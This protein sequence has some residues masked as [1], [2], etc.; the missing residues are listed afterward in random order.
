M[1]SIALT[2]D[3]ALTGT[4]AIDAAGSGGSVLVDGAISGNESLSLTSALSTVEVTGT[5]DLSGAIG[6]ALVGSAYDSITFD[7]A[8]N[9]SG[10]TNGGTVSLSSSQSSVI[11]NDITT[12]GT[13]GLG[14]NISLQ[15]STLM[16]STS[17][18]ALPLGTIQFTGTVFDASGGTLGGAIE[19]SSSGHASFPSVATIFSS[20]SLNNSMTFT[21]SSFTMGANEAMTIYGNVTI[22]VTG[23]VTVSDIIALNN[24]TIDASSIYLTP[25]SSEQI[26]AYFGTLYTSE[27][28]HLL[29]GTTPVFSVSV[30]PPD[31]HTGLTGATEAQ[32]IYAP[33]SLALNYDTSIPPPPPP[34]PVPSNSSYL[35]AVADAQLSDMLPVIGTCWEWPYLPTF[36][37]DCQEDRL[38]RERYMI[39]FRHF[40]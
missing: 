23:S 22:S 28:A 2:G 35:L 36:C 10:T 4:V 5:V 40:L 13:S 27:S 1:G 12:S 39:G 25:R 20:S 21:G 31:S 17:L 16:Q 15:P 26:L 8:I 14:G 9:T 32:L 37:S 24:M 11:V 33:A 19:L 3:V 18:G 29:A 34:V 30:T 7:A 6:G 38:C